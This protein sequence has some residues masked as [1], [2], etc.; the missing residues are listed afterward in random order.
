MIDYDNAFFIDKAGLALILSQKGI[1]TIHCL[2]IFGEDIEIDDD[3]ACL[4]LFS[5]VNEQLVESD[6][7]GSFRLNSQFE[8]ACKAIIDAK[9]IIAVYSNDK[10]SGSLVVYKND[11]GATAVMQAE[12]RRDCL[13]VFE[14]KAEELQKHIASCIEQCGRR[15]SRG[16]DKTL[17][18]ESLEFFG[19]EDDFEQIIVNPQTA[20]FVEVFDIAL[21]RPWKKLAVITEAGKQWLCRWQGEEYS[22]EEYNAQTDLSLDALCG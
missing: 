12:N 6:E 11:G 1:S 7:D 21:Q 17:F 9:K 5:M 16:E 8:S 18:V 20:V 19:L 4:S 13:K 15:N 22:F 2:N 10:N 14:I 3:E